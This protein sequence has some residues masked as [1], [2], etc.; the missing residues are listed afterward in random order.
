MEFIS[1]TGLSFNPSTVFARRG[2]GQESKLLL[3]I[4]GELFIARIT[5]LALTSTN[6]I[7][8]TVFKNISAVLTEHKQAHI[9]LEKMRYG[10]ES[11]IL[12]PKRE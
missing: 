7:I 9:I 1:Q 10:K 11:Y 5:G 4:T 6:K 8:D 3:K 12:K 2:P